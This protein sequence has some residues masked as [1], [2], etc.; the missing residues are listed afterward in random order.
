[1]NH[2]RIPISSRSH[3]RAGPIWS[4]GV[5]PVQN[6]PA[7]FSPPSYNEVYAYGIRPASIGA[8]ASRTAEMCQPVRASI[9]FS[10]RRRPTSATTCWTGP[11]PSISCR[12][13]RRPSIPSRLISRTAVLATASQEGPKMP[14]EP[15]NGMTRPM[16]TSSFRI[17]PSPGETERRV[18]D[19]TGPLGIISHYAHAPAG[20]KGP[21]RVLG[22]VRR[23]PL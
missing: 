22:T 17:A 7:R 11:P 1:M 16:R 13:T 18:L 6:T 10:A 14:V 9:L 5:S 23:R 15:C 20:R 12:L 2:R 21:P 4:S 3:R 19:G 8:N